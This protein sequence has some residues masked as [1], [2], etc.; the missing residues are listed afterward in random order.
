MTEVEKIEKEYKKKLKDAQLKDQIQKSIPKTDIN[1]N[2]YPYSLYGSIA[3]IQNS[4]RPYG[5]SEFNIDDLIECINLFPPED[6]YSV[7]DGCMAFKH[8]VSDKKGDINKISP[9]QINYDAMVQY[10][11][12]ITISWYT[13]LNDYII[14]VD[15]KMK[16]NDFGRIVWFKNDYPGG[17]IIE[18]RSLNVPSCMPSGKEIKWASGGTE[19][20][21]SYTKYFPVEI[22]KSEFIN[23]LE[24]LKKE[25]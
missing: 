5:S 20:I 6:K 24:K 11:Q 22:G 14:R 8:D 18:T 17:Y 7:R 1:F 25:K 12:K 4:D 2:V 13:K 10:G 23:F 9:Y 3:S 15:V 16:S 19:Y 21:N